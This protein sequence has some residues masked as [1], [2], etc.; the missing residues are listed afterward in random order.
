MNRYFN[1]LVG[2]RALARKQ[3]LDSGFPYNDY[4][5][6]F[7]NGEYLVTLDMKSWGKTLCLHCYFTT[8]DG[9]KIILTAYE[10]NGKYSPDKFSIDMSDT[11]IKIG[12]KFKVE[13]G[14][15]NNGRAKW[16]KVNRLEYE[17]V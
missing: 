5:N 13:V 10:Y 11:N 3:L 2:K 15:T 1:L 7:Q 9:D 14:K 4:S 16:L 12:D 17:G 6:E 8:D